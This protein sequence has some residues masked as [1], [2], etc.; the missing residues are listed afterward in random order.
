[1]IFYNAVFFKNSTGVVE[2]H[3]PDIMGADSKGLTWE[4]AYLEAVRTL[5]LIVKEL[6]E[7]PVGRT[8]DNLK[9]I[10]Y[11]EIIPVPIDHTI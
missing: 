6:E 4:D 5:S 8:K 7:L 1:M 10:Y 9:T 11:S 3:F 2:F